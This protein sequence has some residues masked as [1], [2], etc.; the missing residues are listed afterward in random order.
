[1]VRRYR[2]ER[3]P[4]LIELSIRQFTTETVINDLEVRLRNFRG[5]FDPDIR[6]LATFEC[7]GFQFFTLLFIVDAS[8]NDLIAVDFTL[9]NHVGAVNMP[10]FLVLLP[11]HA[12]NSTLQFCKSAIPVG[13]VRLS[14]A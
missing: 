8:E 10:I 1:M 9:H 4:D 13:H 2:V 3:H 11:K 6:Q 12:K 5:F 14:N 7:N